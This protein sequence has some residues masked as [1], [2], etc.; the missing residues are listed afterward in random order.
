VQYDIYSVIALQQLIVYT[1]LNEHLGQS[2]VQNNKDCIWKICTPLGHV[3][4]LG[5]CQL[6]SEI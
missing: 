4:T 5:V 6:I 2:A 3:S 1:V